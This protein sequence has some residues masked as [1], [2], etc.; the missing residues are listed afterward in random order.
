M[1]LKVKSGICGFTTMIN[2]ESED[3]QNVS[4]KIESDCPNIQRLAEE[5][6]EV[7][8]FTEL[9]MKFDGTIHTASKAAGLCSA[10]CPVPTGLH[11]A[12]Q[13]SAGLALPADASIEFEK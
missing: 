9:R 3:M 10:G 13:V 11:K 2:A 1:N 5:L 8:A 6:G 7:D 12:V 4:L